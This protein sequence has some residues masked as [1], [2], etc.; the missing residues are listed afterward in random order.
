MEDIQKYLTE[1]KGLRSFEATMLMK[2]LEKHADIIDE[3]RSVIKTNTVPE[4]GIKSGEWT[5]KSLKNKLPQLEIYTIYEFLAGLRD[6]PEKY[7]KYIADGTPY[8]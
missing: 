3:F 8:L 4:N 2:R 5:A 6:K 1:T 7:Q